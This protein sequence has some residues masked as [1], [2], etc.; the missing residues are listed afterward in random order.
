MALLTALVAVPLATSS[1]R[2]DSAA[3]TAAKANLADSA[4]IIIGM[5]LGSITGSETFKKLWPMILAKAGDA[6]AGLADVQKTCGLDP[7]SVISDIVIAADQKSEQGAVFI[8][9]KGLDEAKLES[10]AIAMTKAK[11]KPVPTFKKDGDLMSVVD[12][13]KQ[14]HYYRWIG[15]DV[16]V[17]GMNKD[18]ADKDSLVK[19]TSGK[20]AF[21]KGTLGTL[22]AKANSSSA[23]WGAASVGKT[24]E[25]GMDVKSGYGWV[26]LSGGTIGAE[27]HATMSDAKAATDTATKANSQITAMK[28]QKGMPPAIGGLLGGVKISSSGAEVVV[29]ATAKEADLLSLAQ[30]AGAF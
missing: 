24:I 9:V 13:K 30:M 17:F 14:L 12:E 3:Y 21:A 16:L 4:N 15:K 11:N 18:M 7:M 19:W 27:V 2:A 10:C 5:N 8:G 28:G 25:P 23:G 22:A 6:Q 29:K 1:A 20:G 26:T